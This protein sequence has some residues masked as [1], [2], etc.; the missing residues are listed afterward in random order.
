MKFKYSY[1]PLHSEV[2]FKDKTVTE[3]NAPKQIIPWEQYFI[4]EYENKTY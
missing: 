4:H 2:P 1:L 3:P